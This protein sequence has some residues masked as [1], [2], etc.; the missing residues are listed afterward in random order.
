[1]PSAP[2]KAFSALS[3]TIH[4]SVSTFDT[5]ALKNRPDSRFGSVRQHRVDVSAGAVTARSAPGFAQ[6]IALAFL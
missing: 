2:A 4:S 5:L 3:P 6:P 1:M